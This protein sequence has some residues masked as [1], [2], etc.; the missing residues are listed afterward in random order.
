MKTLGVI[1]NPER[2]LYESPTPTG[3]PGKQ[4]EH[5]SVAPRSSEGKGMGSTISSSAPIYTP[6]EVFARALHG[7]VLCLIRSIPLTDDLFTGEAGSTMQP[8][9]TYLLDHAENFSQKLHTL[10]GP[11]R[12]ERSVMDQLYGFIDSSF[13]FV[14]GFRHV[15]NTLS[16]APTKKPCVDY[17]AFRRFLERSGELKRIVLI[18]SDLPGTLI[19]QC[20]MAGF[21]VH[22]SP[23]Y[24]HFKR[25]RR[26]EDGID[27]KICWEIAK[28]VYTNK[29]PG[30]NNKIIF[31]SGSR[32]LMALFSDIHTSH[33]AF[34]LWAWK[35]SFSDR[36]LKQAQVF[37][38]VRI[39]DKEWK[40][41]LRLSDARPKRALPS[42]TRLGAVPGSS[43][44]PA[45]SNV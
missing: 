5:R 31:C 41:F 19:S 45:A 4:R 39:L 25:S 27:Q 6:G 23:R 15:R 11:R 1:G 17:A 13:L 38:T 30:I 2:I 3:R 24:P 18:G 32:D 20:Q 29:D 14:E 26:K 21:D 43:Q 22:T 36:Y 44:M 7:A 42:L 37:G 12:K 10:G 40:K 28:T 33:W 16:L 35:N 34:E 9:F 8:H